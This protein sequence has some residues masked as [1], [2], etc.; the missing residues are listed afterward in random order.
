MATAPNPWINADLNRKNKCLYILIRNGDNL[1]RIYT[2]LWLGTVLL[3]CKDEYDD[4]FQDRWHKE[5]RLRPGTKEYME[6]MERAQKEQRKFYTVLLV[7]QG[8]LDRTKVFAP[9]PSE[10]QIN[11][12]NMAEAQKFFTFRFDAENLLGDGRP[13]FS[14]WLREV[15]GALDI[16]CRVIG[17]FDTYYFDEYGCSR[18][19]KHPKHA[20]NPNENCLHVLEKKVGDDEFH[21]YYARTGETVY[22]SW[23]EYNPHEPKKRARF[24]ISRS[25]K[26]VLNFDAVTVADMEYYIHS[27]LNRH[28]YLSMIPLLKVAIK[29]K[30]A[31][32]EQEE[33]FRKLLI[34]EIAKKHKVDHFEA[35]RHIDSLIRWWK[36][37]VREHRALTSDD[38]KALRMIVGEFG[39]R[40]QLQFD[41]EDYA[42]MHKMVVE[43]FTVSECCLA[44]FYRRNME[45]TVYRWHNNENVFVREETW[46]LKNGKLTLLDGTDWT[47]VDKRHESWQLLYA[48][49][50]WT[51]WG[52]GARVQ[53]HLTDPERENIVQQVANKLRGAEYSGWDKERLR[54]EGHKVWKVPLAAV[55]AR[56]DE[57]GHKLYL[58]YATHHS[59][60]PKFILS[61]FMEGPQFGRVAIWW[62]K[63]AGQSPTFKCG[64]I[65]IISMSTKKA[66]W[67][68]GDVGVKSSRN[69]A[70]VHQEDGLLIKSWP[71]NIAAVAKEEEAIAE[72]HERK[73]K[74][75]YPV[76]HAVA[77]V[78]KL[79]KAMWLEKEHEK[80]LEEYVDDEDGTLW[81]DAKGDIKKPSG[82]YVSWFDRALDYLAERG[83]NPNGWTIQQIVDEATKYGYKHDERHDESLVYYDEIKDRTIEYNPDQEEHVWC[84]DDDD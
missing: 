41:G 34:G 56:T 23:G 11:V 54:K 50:K 76:S 43:E 61:G 62:E 73:E 55:I 35:E 13:S 75:G 65:A 60:I 3:P 32:A 29:M 57:Q 40:Q 22:G 84:R 63:K 83:I 78:W 16:G 79:V 74:L 19:R 20:Y 14:E 7:I 5:E 82:L 45:Y 18:D 6:A 12:C 46:K 25:D 66:P 44:V 28:G 15:N 51:G 71:E 37:K 49:D 64:D 77:Q 70:L 2:T 36:F 27:R 21:M 52:I 9:L 39:R 8:L 81:E 53:D 42:D 80:F 67:H 31:E 26:F 10:E 30:Q 59:V 72:V 68:N 38:A 48:N 58:Y 47:I 1:Y 17:N 24:S 4:F 33:P 69:F